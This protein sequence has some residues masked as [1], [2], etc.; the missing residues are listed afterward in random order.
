MA[1]AAARVMKGELA[2]RLAGD[3]CILLLFVA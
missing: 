1:A 2:N 3:K